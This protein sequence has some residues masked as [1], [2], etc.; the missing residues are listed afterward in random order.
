MHSDK[1]P[2]AVVTY[3]ASEFGATTKPVY[4]AGGHQWSDGTVFRFKIQGSDHLLKI[5]QTEDNNALLVTQER[6]SFSSF[7]AS[8]GINTLCPV[9][10]LDGCFVKA[11][12]HDEKQFIAFA[13]QMLEGK[14]LL[15]HHPDDLYDFYKN[16]G[17]LIGRMHSIAKLYP[18]WNES[19]LTN[20]DGKSILSWERE[21][22]HFFYSIPDAEVKSAWISMKSKLDSLPKSRD[23][24]G[25]IHNDPH[26]QNMLTNN[27][28][29]Y[30]IDFDV[31]NYHWFIVDIAI[32]I[33]SEFSRIGFHSKHRSALSD[34][35]HLFIRPFIDGYKENNTLA[36]DQYSQIE[37]F[38]NYRRFLMFTI[39]YEQIKSANPQYLNKFKSEIVNFCPFLS[40]KARDILYL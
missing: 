7:L 29:L 23:N 37:V 33:Y 6:Q 28:K 31:A 32:C 16:W 9:K 2:H 14:P 27:A 12:N 35:P 15:D 17:S 5:I 8:R 20:S 30:L 36:N 4:F 3:F 13:W 40:D 19:P 1:T 21:W 11:H 10:A 18:T 24:F 25:F 26:P 22:E 39:F 38:L 34:L